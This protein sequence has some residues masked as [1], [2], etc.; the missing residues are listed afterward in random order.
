MSKFE[1]GRD[2]LNLDLGNLIIFEYFS[3]FLLSLKLYNNNSRIKICWPMQF[4]NLLYGTYTE[5][6]SFATL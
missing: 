4:Q 5:D 6:H 2:L 1:F 3:S